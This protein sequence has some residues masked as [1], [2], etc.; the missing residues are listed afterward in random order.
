MSSFEAYPG[1]LPIPDDL[2]QLMH[3]CTGSECS[4]CAWRMDNPIELGWERLLETPESENG[5]SNLCGVDLTCSQV[6]NPYR[7][8]FTQQTARVFG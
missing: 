2:S 1:V 3:E 4:F 8:L 6:E 7:K 5:A